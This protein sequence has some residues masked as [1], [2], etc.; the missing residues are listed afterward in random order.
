MAL[1]EVGGVH[2]EAAQ[3]LQAAW[4]RDPRQSLTW[5]IGSWQDLPSAS[6]DAAPQLIVTLGQSAWRGVVERALAQPALA[7]VPLLAALLPQSGYQDLAAKVALRSTAVFLDQPPARYVQLLQLAQPDRKRV[8]VLF[9]PDSISAKA[10]LARAFAARGLTLVSATVLSDDK[11]IYPALRALLDEADILLAL[12]DRLVFNAGTMPNI[13]V[14]AYRQRVPLVSYS[15]AH[16]RAGALLALHTG[17]TD[18][19]GQ[20]VAAMRQIL[21]GRG[22]PPPRMADGCS[23]AINE[24]VARS[25][26]LVLPDS[27]VLARTLQRESVS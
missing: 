23:V 6:A 8:G 26:D 10:E 1:S 2:L 27:R 4:E 12:P 15:A 16:V 3:A 19:I 21:S 11:A 14:T 18:T 25:L 22:L 20:I 13:L 7:R 5:R 24:Q 9:G 17:A